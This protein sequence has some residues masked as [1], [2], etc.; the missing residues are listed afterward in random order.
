MKHY[1]Y[2][3]IGGGIAGDAATRGIR[4][5][6]ADGSIGLISAEPDAPYMRPNLSKGLW[7]GRPLE[8]I[9]RKTEERAELLL[10]RTVTG[11]DTTKKIVNDNKGGEY[12][13]DKLLIATGGSPIRLPFGLVDISYFRDL[14]DYQRLR[15]M[16]D[17]KNRFVVIGGG[18]IGSEIAAA[19]TMVGKQ[20]TMI[21][22]E[23]A[24][25]GRVF[26]SDLAQR[27]NEY[28]REKGVDVIANDSVASIQMDGDRLTVQT[29]SG[30][31]I[32][33][34]GV[35]AGIGI[36][37]NVSLAQEA[38]L[39]VENGIVVNENLQTSAPDVYAAGD[40]V[41]FFHTALEKRAR[42]EHEDNAV[43]MGKL[44]GR[45]MAG[46]GETYNHIPMFYSDLFDLGY[47]AVGEM[48]S[49][50]ETV[51]DWNEPFKKGVIYYLA[52]G[53]VRGVLLWNV[54]KKLGEARA[55][56][57]DQGPFKAEELKGRIKSE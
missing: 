52:D 51:A 43:A 35:V 40:A 42:L 8:K 6:D 33:A 45:N 18:F 39:N 3:I 10:G 53:R 57:A 41:N 24:I 34:D 21:F 13:Y 30:R 7:K 22:L 32:E 55:L 15:K 46:A 19:L 56:I 29:G 37:P 50:M 11:L 47:E 27:L 17:E 48:N 16:A 5:L 26:P 23:D 36:R 49:E 25:G 20:V 9:W 14:Q 12:T 31:A 54:W 28:Y 38:G 1:K 4:E 2:L 44:A